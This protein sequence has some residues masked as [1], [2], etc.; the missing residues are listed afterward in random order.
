MS[1]RENHWRGLAD[2]HT[3]A[4]SHVVTHAEQAPDLHH[5]RGRN[6]RPLTGQ[7][8][9]HHAWEN[10]KAGPLRQQETRLQDPSRLDPSRSNCSGV[11]RAA[12]NVWRAARCPQFTTSHGCRSKRGTVVSGMTPILSGRC[13]TDVPRFMPET[14]SAVLY[15][16]TSPLSG[17][18]DKRT[19]SRPEYVGCG[20]ST[21]RT[22]RPTA[23]CRIRTRSVVPP[24]LGVH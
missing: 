22:I 13:R 18:S 21:P 23:S 1:F 2:L 15:Q 12:R 16:Q 6:P 4:S 10:A 7:R 9:R 8:R 20:C 17:S 5:P 14:S 11:H 24:G 3:V 19:R